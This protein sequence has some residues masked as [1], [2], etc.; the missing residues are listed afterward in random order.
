M[1]MTAKYFENWIMQ[2]ESHIYA[3]VWI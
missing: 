3:A 2:W 1:P